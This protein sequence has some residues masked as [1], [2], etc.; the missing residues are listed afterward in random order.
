MNIFFRELKAS[1]KSLLIWSAIVIVF[2]LLGFSK[3][4]AYYQK[5]EMLAI[6]DTLPK[7]WIDAMNLKAFNLTTLTG[8]YGVCLP[9][10]ALMLA[11]A[12]MMWG[13]GT[14]SREERDKTVEFSLTLPVTRSKLVIAKAAAAV[15]D[16]IALL[17][18]TWGF[19]LI[20]AR[21]YAPDAAFF[22]FVA[23]SALAYLIIEMIF[24]AL[25]IFLG[26]AMRKSRQS[27]GLGIGILLATYFASI[28][29]TLGKSVDFLKY[30]S[31]FKYFDAFLMLK[32]SRLDV[33]YVLLSVAII[34]V[35]MV[36][37]FLIYRKR[38]L[39]I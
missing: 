28:V 17:L 31:P 33:T 27:S 12:A 29:A 3:F 6:L 25:G 5:P 15:V 16:C 11:I 34:V 13:N 20:G 2:A 24:L 23:I 38:D 37:A 22:R 1:L 30:F 18:V 26:C 4:S 10:F 21:Q 39:Y 8:F 35:C 7:G 36:G 19:I 14:I 9:F 32:E